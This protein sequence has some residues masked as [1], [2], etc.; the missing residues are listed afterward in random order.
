[1]VNHIFNFEK[2]LQITAATFQL[3]EEFFFSKK[4]KSAYFSKCFYADFLYFI[5]GHHTWSEKL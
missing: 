5:F 3:K 1:M 2:Y 4:Q